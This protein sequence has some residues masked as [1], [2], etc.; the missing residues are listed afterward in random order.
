MSQDF[1]AFP[2]RIVQQVGSS[3]STTF[4]SGLTRRELFAAMAMSG[5]V[6]FEPTNPKSAADLAVRHADALIAELEKPGGVK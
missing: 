3:I 2:H 5:L 4:N 6:Q 1:P